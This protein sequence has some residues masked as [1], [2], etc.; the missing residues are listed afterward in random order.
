M[1]DRDETTKEQAEEATL[2]Q[3]PELANEKQHIEAMLIKHSGVIKHA[4]QEL[5]FSR[6][7]LYRRIDKYQIDLDKL[8]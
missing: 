5:G 1:P 8:C 2:A 7:A 6:Q 3:H 4:A